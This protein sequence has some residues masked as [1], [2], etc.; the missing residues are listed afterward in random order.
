MREIVPGVIAYGNPGAAAVQPRHIT[1][2]ALK[3]RMTSVERIAIRTAAAST[4]AVADW[5]DLADSARYID[6]DLA[7]TRAG[8]EAL[9]TAG[10]LAAGRAAVILD[11]SIT[12]SER[13]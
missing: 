10:L 4:A 2:Y 12:E 13:P 8:V 9:E 1:A 6:L 5:V 7:A 11:T 3:A